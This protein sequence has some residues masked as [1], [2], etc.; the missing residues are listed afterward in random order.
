M[1]SHRLRTEEKSSGDLGVLVPLGDQ[2]EDLALTVAELG[3]YLGRGGRAHVCEVAR[4]PNGYLRAKDGFAAT[5]R[6][7]GPDHLFVVRSLE[8]VTSRSGAHRRED[9]AVILEHG[10]D[11]DLHMRVTLHDCAGGFDTAYTWHLDVHHDHIGLQFSSYSSSRREWS[12]WLRR[13]G[14]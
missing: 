12:P 14:S 8:D 4:E 2:V 5:D 3:E 1:V 13:A 11:Q 7:Y 10:D 6:P 9:C